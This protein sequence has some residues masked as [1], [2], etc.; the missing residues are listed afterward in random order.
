MVRRRWRCA[1]H[2]VDTVQPL[3]HHPL[4]EPAHVAT[5]RETL[6]HRTWVHGNRLQGLNAPDC[7]GRARQRQR[8]VLG[9]ANDVL[10]AV[11]ELHVHARQLLQL[12]EQ[13]SSL[14]DED[15]DKIL[16]N[17]DGMMRLHNLSAGG[18]GNSFSTHIVQAQGQARDQRCA[19]RVREARL[20]P[21]AHRAAAHRWHLMRMVTCHAGRSR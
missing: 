6:G 19:G 17:N 5:T 4:C 13:D 12:S 18:H 2:A 9:H 15:A 14:A 16:R 10:R 3:R 20:T 21:V 1:A 11:R 7:F 8:A